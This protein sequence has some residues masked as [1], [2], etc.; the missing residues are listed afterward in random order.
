MLLLK[1]PL[2]FTSLH[3]PGLYWKGKRKHFNRIFR[4][5]RKPKLH[6]N[7]HSCLQPISE[8]LRFPLYCSLTWEKPWC[9]V[10]PNTPLSHR[11]WQSISI[12]IFNN[13]SY[14][15]LSW[16]YSVRT[17][18]GRYSLA[19]INM[20]PTTLERHLDLCPLFHP[21]WCAPPL[22]C[23]FSQNDS[24]DKPHF[25]IISKKWQKLN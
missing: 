15:L 12:R 8:S 5:N 17:L 25:V 9:R 23:H 16:L 3:F 18:N 2:V 21:L 6:K 10:F 7:V 11:G 19:T 24:R 4:M 13:A 14:L 20:C 22:S 1:A